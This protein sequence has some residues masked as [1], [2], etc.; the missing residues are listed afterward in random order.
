VKR[1]HKL[2]AEQQKTVEELRD[3]LEDWRDD[4][5]AQYKA[6]ESLLSIVRQDFYPKLPKNGLTTAPGPMLDEV[7]GLIGDLLDA[8]ELL[9]KTAV[10]LSDVGE[11]ARYVRELLPVLADGEPLD[12]EDAT[13]LLLAERLDRAFPVGVLAEE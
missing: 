7:C 2:L 9:T 1:L 10:E 11:L 5:Q 3:T 4:A 13:M 6:V 12:A 8:N